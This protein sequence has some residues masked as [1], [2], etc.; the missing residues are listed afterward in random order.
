MEDKSNCHKC[1]HRGTIPGDA[2]S[3]CN[4]PEAKVKGHPGGIKGGW[5]HHPY[6]FDPTWLL[7][8]DGFEKRGVNTPQVPDTAQ[9]EPETGQDTG[10]SI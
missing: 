5:F 2:H 8:C 6:N 3:R 9:S 4:N 7:E 1:K 10:E